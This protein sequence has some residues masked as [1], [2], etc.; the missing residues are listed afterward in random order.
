MTSSQQN[1]VLFEGVDDSVI[2]R[3]GDG[4]INFWNRSAEGLYGWKKEEAVGRVSHDLLQTQ[5]PKSLEEIESELVRNGR[6]EGKLVHTTRDGS[7]VAVQSRWTLEPNG[8]RGEVVEI[9]APA[10]GY[11]TGPEGRTDSSSVEIGRQ[12]PPLTSRSKRTEELVAKVADIVL[13]AGGVFCILALSY[14]VYYYDWTEQRSFTSRTGEFVYFALPGLVAISLFA[15]LALRKSYR[16]NVAL[17]CCSVAFTMYTAEAVMTV[18]FRL[19]SVIADQNRQTRIEAARALGIK[20]D[21][22]TRAEFIHDLRSQGID[23]VPSVS[24]QVLLKEQKDGTRKS[25]I[26]INGAEVL[27]LASIANK[28]TVVC[29]E[30]GEFLTYRSDQHGFHNPRDI[31]RSSVDIV[32][33]GDSFTQGHCVPS[34]SNFV[35]LIRHRYPQ[36]LNLGIEGNGSLV[37]LATLKEYAESVRPKIVLWFYFEGNDLK[38]LGDERQNALLSRYLTGSDFTQDLLNRQTEI[39]RALADYVATVAAKSWFSVKLEEISDTITKMGFLGTVKNIVKI[40]EVRQRLRLVHGTIEEDSPF[41]EPATPT[42]ADRPQVA[43]LY[44]ILL[45][46]KNLVSSWGG[47]LYFVYLPAVKRYVP[48]EKVNAGRPAVL[49]TAKKAGIPVIDIHPAFM[50]QK[51]PRSL[52]TLRLSSYVHYNDE[53]HRLVAEEVLQAISSTN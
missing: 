37:M 16:I 30:S 22:R 13:I 32:A 24:P 26:D 34:D 47:D 21:R 51:D 49:E 45:Q 12:D 23:A 31:W 33:V 14:F 36:T 44:E 11:K 20:F 9:N 28:L 4:I 8:E 46:A 50:A 15:C 39:D 53:G 48:E 41:T 42:R 27:P 19:P 7:R 5:F 3:T 10:T 43:L 17:C 6:W 38:D 25:V 29:N 2:T 35:S 18:W 40:N 1:E 52:F